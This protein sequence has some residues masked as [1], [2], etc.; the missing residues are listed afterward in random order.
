MHFVYST[1]CRV[2][3][4]HSVMDTPLVGFRLFSVSVLHDLFD[5][6]SFPPWSLAAGALYKSEATASLLRGL[7]TA[8]YSILD[9]VADR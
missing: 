4:S 2:I 9:K 5:K 6:T 7:L 8:T 1:V 3:S